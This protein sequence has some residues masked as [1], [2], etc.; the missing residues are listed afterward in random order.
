MRFLNEAH[1]GSQLSS[2][3][4]EEAFSSHS[5]FISCRKLWLSEDLRAV[6]VFLL[7]K[8]EAKDAKNSPALRDSGSVPTAAPSGAR[9]LLAR[10][11]LGPPKAGKPRAARGRV[12]ER[13]CGAPISAGVFPD[14]AI[15]RHC[16]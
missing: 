3:C 9:P 1:P 14:R 13:R 8:P 15:A 16:S 4:F 7:L 10:P 5:S 12:R 6:R 2:L 11:P